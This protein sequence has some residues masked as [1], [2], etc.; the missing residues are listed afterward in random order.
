MQVKPE[1][2]GKGIGSS[3]LKYLAANEDLAGCYCLPYSHLKKF[4][5]LIGFE[6]I[7]VQDTPR[8]LAKRLKA[9]LHKGLDVMAMRIN[10]KQKTG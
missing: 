2:Q 9:Y 6:E 1:W 4:Y 3:M 5:G 8:F 7:A 10:R